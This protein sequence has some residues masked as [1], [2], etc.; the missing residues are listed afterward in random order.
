MRQYSASLPGI[1]ES[2]QL[3]A[4]STSAGVAQK[5]LIATLRWS[6]QLG[7]WL[8]EATLA[9]QTM[10][11]RI[12]LSQRG[13][14]RQ[15]ARERPPDKSNAPSL[16]TRTAYRRSFTSRTQAHDEVIRACARARTP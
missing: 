12:R 1:T 7:A 13:L 14:N 3:R 6:P 11:G 15:I 8:T 4:E 9:E 16:R 5:K 2:G 10:R